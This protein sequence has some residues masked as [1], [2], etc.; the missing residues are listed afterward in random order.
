MI[1]ATSTD[2]VYPL[3]TSRRVDAVDRRLSLMTVPGT[4]L[5][6]LSSADMPSENGMGTPGWNAVAVGFFVVL[7]GAGLLPLIGRSRSRFGRLGFAAPT[8]VTWALVALAGMALNASWFWQPTVNEALAPWTWIL[9]PSVIGLA[10]LALRPALAYAVAL[11]WAASV[12]VGSLL[13]GVPLTHEVLAL[14]AVHSADVVFVGMYIIV[15]RQLRDR[16]ASERQV[17]HNEATLAQAH[18]NALQR[19]RVTAF[20]HDDVLTTLNAAVLGHEPEAL[21]ASAVEARRLIREEI[22]RLGLEIA[23]LEHA[24][25]DHDLNGPAASPRL[26]KSAD[27]MSAADLV[28]TLRALAEDHETSFACELSDLTN[29]ELTGPTAQAL[30]GAT[31]EALRNALLHAPGATRSLEISDQHGDL[32]IE[33]IDTGPGFDPTMTS[34]LRLGIT[35]SILGRVN[36]HPSCQ[37]A[38][39]SRPGAG[40]RV[41]LTW[42]LP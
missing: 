10:T 32:T 1:S 38:V 9:G 13:A 35:S 23:A 11:G 17:V 31:R 40:T 36:S 26:T 27:N 15:R 3:S 28:A 30:V 25:V 6:V 22:E 29:P 8:R 20:V 5:L 19:A 7:A 16:Y 33:I 24:P 37:A 4:I 21:T 14:T 42:T 2:G 18:E 12:P 41:V 34:P 39:M